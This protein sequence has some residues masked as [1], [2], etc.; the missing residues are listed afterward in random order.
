[1]SKRQHRK[2]RSFEA[3]ADH[4]H[5]AAPYVLER[6]QPV[7]AAAGER[8]ININQEIGERWDGSGITTKFVQAE[9]KRFGAGP[10]TV[11]ID[12][13]GGDYFTGLAVRNVFAEHDGDITVNVIGLAA[14]AASVIAMAADTLRIGKKA[15]IMIHKSWT[16]VIGNADDMTDA[17]ELSNQL[18]A[19][20]AE[21]YA[22]RTGMTEK[23]ILTYMSAKRGM[24]TFFSGKEAVDLGFA[25]E[26]L[27]SDAVAAKIPE[28]VS[29]L[30]KME[31]Q[32]MK[33]GTPRAERRA[34]LQ[35]AK[36]GKLRAA[37]DDA[38]PGAGDLEILRTL[39]SLKP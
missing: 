14:S 15:F 31:I 30:Q 26:L 35:K 29:A 23:E 7:Q 27:E 32:L 11:N 12:S 1:M 18:D 38:K 4:E 5:A 21:A 20:M 2:I 25:D 19:T 6:W 37:D 33:A 3:P 39:Q 28:Q 13:P 22:D 24:G 9:L 17:A 34:L 10:I 36:D 8:T 16:I